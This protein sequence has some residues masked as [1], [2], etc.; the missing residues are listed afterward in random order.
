[1]LSLTVLVVVVALIAG[2]AYLYTKPEEEIIPVSPIDGEVSEGEEGGTQIACTMDAR[3]CPDGSYVGRVGPKCEFADCPSTPSVNLTTR[4][5]DEQMIGA[6]ISRWPPQEFRNSAQVK[7]IYRGDLNRDGFADAIVSVFGC[8]ASCGEATFLIIDDGGLP[9]LLPPAP[10][11][12]KGYG[13][14]DPGI[15]VVS[16]K[17][18]IITVNNTKSGQFTGVVSKYRLEGETVAEVE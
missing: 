14:E 17:D 6:A 5:S 4:V 18:G 7:Q 1:M 9:K 10:I 15:R 13:Y 16:I 3:Q 12:I 11:L 2:S 8:G